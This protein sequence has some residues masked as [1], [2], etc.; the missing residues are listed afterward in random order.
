M[1]N[2]KLL[3]LALLHAAEGQS[4]DGITR[5]QKLVFLTQ[6]END[7]ESE[8]DFMA[9]DYGPYSKQLYDALDKLEERD[10]IAKDTEYTRSGNEKYIYSLTE[11]GEQAAERYLYDDTGSSALV[12]AA[13]EIC[14]QFND[15]TLEH[16]LQYV[17]NEYPDFT[18]RSKLNL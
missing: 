10:L 8:Y 1:T 7:F 2:A 17:Y 6:Q 13:S 9:Y 5:L 11:E 4:V 18:T 16:L 12:D 14:D 15:K 3:P